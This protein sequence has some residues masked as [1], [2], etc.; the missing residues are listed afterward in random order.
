MFKLESKLASGCV[1]EGVQGRL[2][3]RVDQALSVR[4]GGVLV[5]NCQQISVGKLHEQW[6]VIRA[7]SAV[8]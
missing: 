7:A 4:R 6:E 5:K 3:H 8:Q 1:F 2:G